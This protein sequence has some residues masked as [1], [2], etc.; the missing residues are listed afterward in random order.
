[1]LLKTTR[2]GKLNRKSI[3]SVTILERASIDNSI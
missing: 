1:M 2:L 3:L